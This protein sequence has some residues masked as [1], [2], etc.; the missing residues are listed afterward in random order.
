MSLELLFVA[1]F[2][3]AFALVVAVARLLP[4]PPARRSLNTDAPTLFRLPGGAIWLAGH[5]LL[6]RVTY[7]MAILEVQEDGIRV[8]PNGAGLAPIVPRWEY[9]WNELTALDIS[10][11]QVVIKAPGGAHPLRFVH[12]RKNMPIDMHE[13]I[14]KRVAPAPEL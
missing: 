1:W 4:A 6:W 2:A 12:L 10:G 14:N 7:P 3:V 11:G 8:G 9:R 13:F 5:W